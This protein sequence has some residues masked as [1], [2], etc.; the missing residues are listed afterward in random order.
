MLKTV[1]LKRALSGNS[2]ES[3]LQYFNQIADLALS[4]DRRN[5]YIAS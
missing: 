2:Q 5:F 3:S 4:L 1:L